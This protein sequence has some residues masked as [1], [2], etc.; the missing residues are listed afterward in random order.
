MTISSAGALGA[1][2]EVGDRRRRQPPTGAWARPPARP[3]ST[4]PP[5]STPPVTRAPPTATPG[6]INGDADG[7]ASFNGTGTGLVKT[8]S[9]A[10]TTPAFSIEAWVKTTSTQGGKIVGYGALADRRVGQLRPPR[11]H[12]QRRPRSSSASTPNAVRTVNS[13]ARLQRRPVAPH[14]GAPRAAAASPSTS[15]AAASARTR[16]P[17][18]PRPTPATGASAATT[19]TAGRTARR[20]STSTARSTTW[21]STRPPCRRPRS[22]PTSWPPAAPARSRRVP[23]TTTAA[24]STTTSRETYFRFNEPSGPTAID[25]S[26]T[27]VNGSLTNDRRRPCG[28][29]GAIGRDQQR[30][31]GEQ[32]PG[33]HRQPDEQPDRPTRPRP[34]SRQ[35][36]DRRRQDRRLRQLAHRHQRQLRPPRLHAQRRQAW[37]TASTPG[38]ST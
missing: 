5:S 14:R 26:Q 38:P 6:A 8:N 29:T 19:S 11:L 35:L 12:G 24:P 2:A 32:R 4:T 34:G 1:Y 37:S 10:A 18:A 9:T 3:P 33:L 15:T 20:A 31:P 28:Q 7:A 25:A 30:H 13:A 21:R 27:G 16:P 17:Q 22:T 23:A 36:D